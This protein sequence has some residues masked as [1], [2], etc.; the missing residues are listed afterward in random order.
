MLVAN[1]P[2][3]AQVLLLANLDQAA[4]L[5]NGA[6]GRIIGFEK[7]KDDMLP[8]AKKH[9]NDTPLNGEQL[10]TH[11]HKRYAQ[12]RI[13]DF[14]YHSKESQLWP[15]VRFTNGLERVIYAHCS[16]T[17]LGAVEPFSLLSRTQIPLIAG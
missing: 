3:P 13:R 6:S 1:V 11:T 14:K 17:E 4:G 8:R 15:I 9:G 2:T 7:M 5:V 10:I 12:E 16:I